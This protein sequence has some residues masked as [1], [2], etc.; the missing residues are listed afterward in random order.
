MRKALGLFL[1][2]V[3]GVWTAGLFLYLA[4]SDPEFAKHSESLYA[5]FEMIRHG[6]LFPMVM[7]FLGTI[8]C[9]REG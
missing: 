2:I 1:A 7:A 5:L 8:I 4:L 9:I 6:G 3:G